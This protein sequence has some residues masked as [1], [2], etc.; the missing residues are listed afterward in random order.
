[1]NIV[2]LG[3]GA[4]GS[5][6]G[7]LMAGADISVTLLDVNDAH[8]SAINKN[9]LIL[10]QD[11]QRS[12]L[13]LPAMRPEAYTGPA[14]LIILLTKT[15]HT[16]AALASV[17][18]LLDNGAYVLTIQN[19]LGN[20][21]R[22]AQ[23]V[24]RERILEGSTMINGRFHGPGDVATNGVSKTTFRAL[25]ERAQPFA[26]E[27]ASLLAPVHF[28]N[29]PAAGVV[30]WQK[31]A[32]NCAMNAI[33]ALAGARVG[34]IGN[35]PSAIALARAASAEVVAI[36]NAKGI[37]VELSAVHAQIEKALREHKPH[38]PSM[39]QDLEAGRP[40]EIESLCGTAEKEASSLGL[41]A[42][43][44]AALAALVRLKERAAKTKWD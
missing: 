1:M 34:D 19:G 41:Q 4:L 27:L 38:K 17:Q 33:A 39:L 44:N 29:E 13:E 14:E 37:P 35:E 3:A 26:E 16:A 22:V 28:V 12:T 42:P 23:T 43:L 24:P 5:V 11:G 31:A 25:S 2:I 15:M 21:D 7:G 6:L 30:I 18:R 9:G 40:T 10:H 20:A 32:F 36:A 8:I